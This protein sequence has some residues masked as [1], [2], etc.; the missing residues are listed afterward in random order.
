MKST[1]T[2]F[3]LAIAV[4]LFAQQNPN[5]VTDEDF[6]T[7]V[8][9]EAEAHAHHFHPVPVA[10]AL[11]GHYDPPSISRCWKMVSTKSTSTSPRNL[12]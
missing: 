2:M 6:E 12:L 8:C 4:S 9:K 5:V 1:F 10:S 11:T 7:I 3:L